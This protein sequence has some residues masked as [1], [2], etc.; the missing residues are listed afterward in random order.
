MTWTHSICDTCWID[1]EGFRVPVRIERSLEVCCFCGH[2]HESGI[3]VRENPQTVLC[4][5]P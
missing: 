4:K 1:R 2:T 5:C 3:Y